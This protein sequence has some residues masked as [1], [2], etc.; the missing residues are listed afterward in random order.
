M[1]LT[2]TDVDHFNVTHQIKRFSFGTDFPGQTNP[3]DKVWTHS[4]SGA[5]VSS[6]FLK[7]V[8]TQYEFLSGE[9][10]RTNQFSVTQYYKAL[11]PRRPPRCCRAPVHVRAARRSAC[12]RPRCA[13]ATLVGFFTRCAAVIGGLFSVAGIRDSA[14]YRVEGDEEGARWAARLSAARR[15]GPFR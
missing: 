7:V 2:H 14:W 9:V 11:A 10:V 12:A 6:Y 1:Q 5:G 15:V 3:L 13:A 4:P 8:P